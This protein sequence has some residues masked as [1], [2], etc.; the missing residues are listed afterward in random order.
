MSN[1]RMEVLET[2]AGIEGEFIALSGATIDGS[3]PFEGVFRVLDLDNCMKRE[4]DGRCV[5]T[6]LCGQGEAGPDELTSV[7]V[8]LPPG[9][10]MPVGIHG[11]PPVPAIHRF[12]LIA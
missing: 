10:P 5:V 6:V 8:V 1:I 12:Q 11:E 9:A 7:E 4:R 2:V 3:A